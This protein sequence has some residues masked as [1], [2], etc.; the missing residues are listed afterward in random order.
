MNPNEIKQFITSFVING[1]HCLRTHRNHLYRTKVEMPYH[2][3]AKKDH[4]L[5][6]VLGNFI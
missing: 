1:Q 6:S 3:I 5:I 4:D 2:L